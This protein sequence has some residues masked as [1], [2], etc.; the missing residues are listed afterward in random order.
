MNLHRIARR[1]I[2][3]ETLRFDFDIEGTEYTGEVELSPPDPKVGAPGQ[4]AVIGIFGPEGEEVEDIAGFMKQHGPIVE[5][6]YIDVIEK[7]EDWKAAEEEEA[8][9]RGRE[10]E[11]EERARGDWMPPSQEP[12]ME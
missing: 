4:A 10:M 12:G 9:E 3:F 5:N 2:A 8:W 6:A 1:V 7:K 11:V